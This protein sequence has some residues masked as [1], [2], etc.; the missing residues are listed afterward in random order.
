MGFEM[1][2]RN[3]GEKE[4]IDNKI[5]SHLYKNNEVRIIY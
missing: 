2:S 4:N 3:E 5:K 1:Y